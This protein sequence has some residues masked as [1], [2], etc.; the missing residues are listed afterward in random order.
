MI[1]VETQFRLEHALTSSQAA[2]EM[3]LRLMVGTTPTTP[4]QAAEILALLDPTKDALLSE[5]LFVGLAGD[6]NGAAGR[7]MAQKMTGMIAVLQARAADAPVAGA[8]AKMGDEPMSDK[9]FEAL[10]HALTD[11]AA[12]EDLRESYDAMVSAIQGIGA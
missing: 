6:G 5:R 11:R 9:T 4:A 1:K 8:K 7:E 10:V 3:T 12:A 2:D